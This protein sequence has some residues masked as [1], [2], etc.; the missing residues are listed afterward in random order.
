MKL[1]SKDFTDNNHIP[2]EFTS[3]GRNISPQLSWQ[4]APEGTKSF[5]LA[6][7]D[8][9]AVGGGWNHWLVYDVPKSVKEISQNSLP[10]GAKEVENDFGR[11]RYGGPSPPSG[12]HRYIFTLYALDTAHID[13]ISSYNFF[14]KVEKH[15]I[16]KA[17]LMGLYKRQR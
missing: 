5:A 13:G 1:T 16:A 15:A 11:K 12:T 4:D 7:T 9:D 6:V 10:A 14:D 17:Q 2:S 8:P 3:D